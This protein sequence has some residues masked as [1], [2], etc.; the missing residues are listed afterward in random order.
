MTL[1]LN[2]NYPLTVLSGI[3]H[4]ACDRSHLSDHV[5]RTLQHIGI[6]KIRLRGKRAGVTRKSDHSTPIR[7]VV[8]Y[9]SREHRERGL[10]N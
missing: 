7:I 6:S 8:D 2:F 1:S 10:L 4:A 3:G 9:R 5:L